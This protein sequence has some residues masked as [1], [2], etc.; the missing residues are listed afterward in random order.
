MRSLFIVVSLCIASISYPQV[1]GK[2][3]GQP[4]TEQR[5]TE[6]APVF[7]KTPSPK[8]EAERNREHYENVEKPWLDRILMGATGV[9]ALFTA[10]LWVATQC[11]VRESKRSSERQLRAYVGVV[12]P[13]IRIDGSKLIAWFDYCNAGQTPA[14][15][16]ELKVSAEI[17]DG[18]IDD[19]PWREA[20][21]HRD[22][23]KGGVMVPST[24][25]QKYCPVSEQDRPDK[26]VQFNKRLQADITSDPPKQRIWLWGTITYTDIF[27]KH[28]VVQFRFWS[29]MD[30]RKHPHN[31]VFPR[32]G[33]YLPVIA[34]ARHTKA[35][36]GKKA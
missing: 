32:K 25:W 2:K 9:L 12:Y 21:T 10:F 16:V 34:D 19:P 11:L 1:G 26:L 30:I 28:N 24:T 22:K 17:F 29:G 27:E 3:D 33:R 7:V 15:N 18:G 14:R 5:G 4:N 20:G 36:Y 23:G 6:E 31:A 35:E 13:E 8:T